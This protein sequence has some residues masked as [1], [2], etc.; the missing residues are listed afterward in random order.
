MDTISSDYLFRP[1]P[2]N[3]TYIQ[4]HIKR[5]PKKTMGNVV[6][7]KLATGPLSSSGWRLVHL[8]FRQRWGLARLSRVLQILRLF[9]AWHG[10]DV[11]YLVTPWNHLQKRGVLWIWYQF[12]SRMA[13][14]IKPGQSNFLR[15]LEFLTLK[16]WIHSYLYSS[17]CFFRYSI[18]NSRSQDLFWAFCKTLC[19]PT[20][21]GFVGFRVEPSKKKHQ[22]TGV[23]RSLPN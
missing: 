3:K 22:S 4:I 16:P 12:G 15:H 8:F 5:I 20:A 17:S 1:A 19:P 2:P 7:Q 11:G 23:W 9:G 10:M 13:I 21:T 6:Q 14:R 18:K